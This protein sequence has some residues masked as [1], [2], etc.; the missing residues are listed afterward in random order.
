MEIYTTVEEISPDQMILSD[1]PFD[2]HCYIFDYLNYD[3][4]L[5]MFRT[6]Q[7][8]NSFRNDNYI[9]HLFDC[10]YSEKLLKLY[11][12]KVRNNK[13]QFYKL[14][15]KRINM[16]YDKHYLEIKKLG[17][18]TRNNEELSI[19]KYNPVYKLE[20]KKWMTKLVENKDYDTY[21][22]LCMIH[23]QLRISGD[24]LVDMIEAKSYEILPA[25]LD[26]SFDIDVT[27]LLNFIYKI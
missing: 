15:H 26:K 6:C 16:L 24:I 12:V 27:R 17:L 11:R 7:I 19:K 3:D 1:L 14:N 4:I 18:Y 13:Q 9:K 22:F 21:F 25:L 2:V 8:F 10:H 5:A 20:M 23:T